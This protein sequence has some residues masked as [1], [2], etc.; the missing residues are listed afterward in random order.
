MPKEFRRIGILLVNV[1]LLMGLVG[2]LA[3][4]LAVVVDLPSRVYTVA[5]REY[6]SYNYG[7]SITQAAPTLAIVETKDQVEA[8]ILAARESRVR[9]TL[10]ARYEEREGV[11]VTVYDLEF[12]SEYI[13][14]YPGS[15]VT[16]TVTLFFPFPSNLETL[17]E[18]SFLVDGEE[19][20]EAQYTL[21]GIG[22]QTEMEAGKEHRIAI[23]YQA[24]GA[25]SFSYG[26]AQ[27]QRS[28][29]LDVTV[30]VLGLEGSEVSRTSLPTT[31]RDV[32]DRG[33]T[34]TW[35]YAGLIA[36][37]DIRLTLPSRLSFAQRV[38]HL[39]GDFSRMAVF[40]PFLVGLF[41]AS[42]AGLLRLGGVSLR[43]ESYLLMGCVLALFY[44][45]LTFLSGVIDLVPAASLA[46]LIVSGLVLLFLGLMGGW[47]QTWWRGG[48]LLVIFLGIFSLG[49]LTPWRGLLF[50]G[51]ALLLLGTFMIAYARQPKVTEPEPVSPE[52]PEPEPMTETS[53]PEEVP[54]PISRHCPHCGRGLAED[55]QFCR[56]CGREISYFRTCAQCG[57]EQYVSPDLEAAHCVHCGSLLR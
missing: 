50:T 4:Y 51:G 17:H 38:A 37:R 57:H 10:D 11:S 18:V 9:A 44:P 48:L 24:D 31:G 15:N 22:W 8:T 54:E 2:L 1:V 25:N 41:L 30:T 49:M 5:Q 46:F 21:Q 39:Q 40:A 23:S 16:A 45:L 56:G 19:P 6:L 53:P 34:F 55:H 26:V 14:A 20:P 43:L 47:R 13:V 3:A 32:V 28:D 33:E 29:V 7:R 35:D 27:G 36:N 12:C 52:A 42:L